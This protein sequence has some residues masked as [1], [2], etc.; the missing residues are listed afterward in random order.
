[1]PDDV[2]PSP[3]SVR[4]STDLLEKLDKIAKALE[5]P[6]SWVLVHA[7]KEYL[8]REGDE[9]LDIQEGIEAADRGELVDLD[10]VIADM[11]EVIKRAEAKRS[12]G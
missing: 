4:L 2:R 1:M 8:K 6:R 7:F 12:G 3:L 11:D 5:R 9:I 10:E